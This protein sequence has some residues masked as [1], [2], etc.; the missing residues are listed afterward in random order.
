M[1]ANNGGYILS[2]YDLFRQLFPQTEQ[3]G[4]T[5]FRNNPIQAASIRI[6]PKI[7]PENP[8][9]NTAT[10]QQIVAYEESWNYRHDLDVNGKHFTS[11]AIKFADHPYKQ[12]NF[13]AL[14]QW[15]LNDPLTTVQ[16]PLAFGTNITG[17][18]NRTGFSQPFETENIVMVCIDSSDAGNS[19]LG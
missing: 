19:P 1:S 7:A 17:Y 18:G 12:S 11:A 5:R 3:V 6:N 13:S 9:V 2:A 16:G 10:Y 8:D 4:L 14:I 15:D